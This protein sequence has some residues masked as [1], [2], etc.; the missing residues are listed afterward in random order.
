MT[1]HLLADDGFPKDPLQL[2]ETNKII[3]SNVKV[4]D[5]T[6]SLRI[7]GPSVE[8]FGNVASKPSLAKPKVV[9]AKVGSVK[10]RL[11]RIM[12]KLYDLET[13]PACI[14]EKQLNMDLAVD[15]YQMEDY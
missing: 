15:L 2:L 8:P 5:R 13:E 1:K 9:R 3:E 11:G 6:R 10:C 14:P 7:G 4:I 12:H